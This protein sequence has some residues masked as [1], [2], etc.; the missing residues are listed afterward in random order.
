MSPVCHQ[1]VIVLTRSVPTLRVVLL[2]QQ[3]QMAENDNSNSLQNSL[4]SA[5]LRGL[6][7]RDCS[8]SYQRCPSNPVGDEQLASYA[9]GGPTSS[10]LAS[11]RRTSG[12]TGW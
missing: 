1:P 4:R 9:I 5:V 12:T 8:R 10:G 3:F 6:R 7:N 11:R 2:T